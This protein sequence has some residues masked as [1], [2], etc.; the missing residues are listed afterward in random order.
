MKRNHLIA[1]REDFLGGALCGGAIIL[2]QL[3]GNALHDAI[4]EV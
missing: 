4:L 1:S 3:S 2:A